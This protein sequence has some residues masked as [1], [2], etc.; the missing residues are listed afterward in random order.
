MSEHPSTL[1]VANDGETVFLFIP[2]ENEEHP[3][4]QVILSSEAGKELAKLIWRHCAI[5]DN[6]N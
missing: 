4:M 6:A 3:E 1:S 2:L 5:V